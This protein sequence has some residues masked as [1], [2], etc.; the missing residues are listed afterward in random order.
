VHLVPVHHYAL[1]HGFH[2]EHQ[3]SVTQ[4]HQMYTA[5]QPKPRAIKILTLNPTNPTRQ[6]NKAQ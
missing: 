3:P 5:Q 4:L 2:G 1:V 6:C